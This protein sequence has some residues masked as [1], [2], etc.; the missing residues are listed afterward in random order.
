MWI[1][2]PTPMTNTG[3]NTQYKAEFKTKKG[4]SSGTRNKEETQTSVESRWPD[5]KEAGSG[6][7]MLE[8]SASH[9]S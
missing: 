8:L 2:P 6:G 5:A 3:W 7:G 4:K 9:D 1:L